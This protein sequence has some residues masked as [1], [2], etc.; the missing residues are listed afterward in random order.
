[1]P[2]FPSEVWKAT[3]ITLD[4]LPQTVRS[5]ANVSSRRRTWLNMLCGT[6]IMV[7]KGKLNRVQGQ[8]G[9]VN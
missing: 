8:N 4:F 7:A 2:R 9:T 6:E 1:M 5:L 3:E